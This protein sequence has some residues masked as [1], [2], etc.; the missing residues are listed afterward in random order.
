[1]GTP[2]EGRA[3]PRLGRRQLL[4]GAARGQRAARGTGGRRSKALRPGGSGGGV[5]AWLWIGSGVGDRG[6]RGRGG[7]LW[8]ETRV[9]KGLSLGVGGPATCPA[10]PL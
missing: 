9:S 3:G 7:S 2:A 5:S 1:M 4:V 8:G 10:L 6:V